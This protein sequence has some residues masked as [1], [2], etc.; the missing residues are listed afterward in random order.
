MNK[1]NFLL[2]MVFQIFC[3]L[4][5][6]E[7]NNTQE[8]KKYYEEYKTLNISDELAKSIEFGFSTTSGTTNTLNL[9]GRFRTY[10][11]FDGVNNK[12][13]KILFDSNIFLTKTNHIK[14][15][16][17]YSANIDFEQSIDDDWLGYG[18]IRLFRNTFKNYN[19][20]FSMNMG[21]GYQFI[22][23][24]THKLTVKVGFGHNRE[25]YTNDTKDKKFMSFNQYIEYNK[26]MTAKNHLYARV[27]FIENIENFSDDYEI[28]STFGLNFMLGK[29]LSFAVEQ[30]IYFDALTPKGNNIVDTKTIAKIGYRF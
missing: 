24:D 15:D 3:S 17:E 14:N 29:N 16:E 27:A 11:T 26:K 25:Y 18:N 7:A 20:I 23:N 21:M 30:E 19:A 12:M 8:I 28:L 1:V 5:Y 6:L 13:F 9:N 4:S 22:Q 2:V 10:F